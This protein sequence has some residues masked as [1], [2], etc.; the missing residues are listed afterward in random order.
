MDLFSFGVTLDG[1]TGPDKRGLI[2]V[3]SPGGSAGI[4]FLEGNYTGSL[5]RE[6]GTYLIYQKTSEGNYTLS[7]NPGGTGGIDSSVSPMILFDNTD[8]AIGLFGVTAPAFPVEY[9][10][11]GSVASDLVFANTSGETF[12][13]RFDS[14][15]VRFDSNGIGSVNFDLGVTSDDGNLKISSDDDN[16]VAKTVLN[17][18]RSGDV[19]VGG[20]DSDTSGDTFGS[21]N[22]VSGKLAVGGNFGTTS[23]YVLTTTGVSAEWKEAAKSSPDFLDDST[24]IFGSD[25]TPDSFDFQSGTNIDIRGF[26]TGDGTSVTGGIVV[27]SFVNTYNTILPVAEAS[28]TAEGIAIAGGSG[29]VVNATETLDTN[30]KRVRL[31]T[32]NAATTSDQAGPT[33]AT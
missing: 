31:Y 8:N 20:L 30:S 11:R 16:G 17:T 23:G 10:S 3:V 14:S 9:K 21:L 15:E 4:L 6:E 18:K 13:V 25:I 26:T 32:L 27:N 28:V 5:T 22:I 33:G 19:V 29:V 7:L 1:N 2:Q 12:G 24:S